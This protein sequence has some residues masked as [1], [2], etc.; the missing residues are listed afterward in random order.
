M[1]RVK[2]AGQPRA[3]RIPRES[4]N[5]VASA[6][7]LP[8]RRPCP[9]HCSMRRSARFEALLALHLVVGRAAITRDSTGSPRRANGSRCLLRRSQAPGLA[10]FTCRPA[11][12]AR[13]SVPFAG[14]PWCGSLVR[15]PSAD[16]WCGPLVRIIGAGPWCEPLV[17]GPPCSLLPGT[18]F[19]PL[20]RVPCGRGAAAGPRPRPAAIPASY[21]GKSHLILLS[22][23]AP[24]ANVFAVVRLPAFGRS[25]GIANSRRETAK[26]F[27]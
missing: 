6:A 19:T 9:W 14:G 25:A 23:P 7:G 18:P 8:N 27:L 26:K 10:R 20:G 15:A 12:V 1:R 16:P 21:A 4:C 24:T 17:Q 11:P 3:G 2:T 5:R 13:R 22:Q